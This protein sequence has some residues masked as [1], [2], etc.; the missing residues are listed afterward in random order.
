V[1]VGEDPDLV[2]F[3]GVK[4]NDG[5]SAHAQE[6]LHRDKGSSQKDGYLDLNL[7]K[8]RIHAVAPLQAC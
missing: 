7:S 8:L 6:L 2:I 5:S 3:L 4:L 1:I